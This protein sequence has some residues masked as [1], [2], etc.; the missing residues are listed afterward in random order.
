MVG[1]DSNQYIA[2]VGIED[3]LCESLVDT[4]GACTLMDM[5][6]A[7]QLGLAYKE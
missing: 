7:G 1:W 3:R 4:G 5:G 2:L 6:M